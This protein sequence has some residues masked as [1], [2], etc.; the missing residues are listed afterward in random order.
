MLIQN[1]IENKVSIDVTV[2]EFVSMSE[3]D[4]KKNLK[5]ISVECFKRNV[6]E[7]LNSDIESAIKLS[8]LGMK[9][10]VCIHVKISD[11]NWAISNLGI[12]RG[13]HQENAFRLMAGFLGHAI[14]KL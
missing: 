9:G 2:K 3:E 12:A 14:Q 13:E 10:D 8:G 6:E 1:L 4:R 11:T 7:F 5:K